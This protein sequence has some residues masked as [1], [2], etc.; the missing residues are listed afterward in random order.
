LSSTDRYGSYRPISFLQNNG[1]LL[2]TTEIISANGDFAAHG[3][4]LTVLS[5]ARRCRSCQ[6]TSVISRGGELFTDLVLPVEIN[7]PQSAYR[8]EIHE[9]GTCCRKQAWKQPGTGISFSFYSMRR[10]LRHN[11]REQRSGHETK[12]P[13]LFSRIVSRLYCGCRSTACAVVSPHSTGTAPALEADRPDAFPP[14]L[15][16]LA[17]QRFLSAV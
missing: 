8:Q 17:I 12:N 13:P 6:S 16:C 9:H 2:N 4:L 7:S 14:P 5:C 3:T 15:L 11:C 10:R 1:D